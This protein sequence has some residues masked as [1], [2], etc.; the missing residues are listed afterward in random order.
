MAGQGCGSAR[1]E[2]RCSG[3][4]GQ[5]ER[6][7]ANAQRCAGSLR[8]VHHQHADAFRA[9]SGVRQRPVHEHGRRQENRAGNG[10]E[11]RPTRHPWRPGSSSA[12]GRRLRWR[13]G[14]RR[15]RPQP[16]RHGHDRLYRRRQAPELGPHRPAERPHAGGHRS[17]KEAPPGFH[18]CRSHGPPESRRR[19]VD[20]GG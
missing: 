3:R 2:H 1:R 19:L 20:G 12:S 6:R 5:G 11:G 16:S 18:D 14:H 13:Q 4:A 10:R 9:Q 7:S 8:H 17:R 15:Q